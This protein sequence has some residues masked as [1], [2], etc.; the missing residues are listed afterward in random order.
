MFCVHLNQL[1]ICLHILSCFS[2]LFE[3]FL[4][5]FYNNFG[6]TVKSHNLWSSRESELGGSELI[7]EYKD[8]VCSWIIMAKISDYLL[9]FDL[10]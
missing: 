4:F 7:Q 6:V 9:N 5:F 3:I 1:K 8:Y 10:F 2:I